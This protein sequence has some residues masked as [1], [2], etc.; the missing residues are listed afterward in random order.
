MQTRRS[1]FTL[2]LPETDLL[3]GRLPPLFSTA[4]DGHFNF[5]GFVTHTS[6]GSEPTQSY[7]QL[8]RNGCVEGVESRLLRYDPKEPL[9]L[10][11]WL[12]KAIADGVVAYVRALAAMGCDPP[13]AVMATLLGVLGYRLV[14]SNDLGNLLGRP[15]DRTEL[16]IPEVTVEA[17]GFDPM[18]ELRPIFD[19]I[20]NACGRP[21]SLNYDEAGKWLP[22]FSG[23]I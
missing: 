20:W 21:R 4:W 11:D 17:V 14:R 18:Q 15:V 13:F 23:S 12:E 2:N 8:F 10:I 19:V 9:I 5:D 6:P 7:L 1:S 16:V 3:K 22:G